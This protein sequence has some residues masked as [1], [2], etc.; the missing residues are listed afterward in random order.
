MSLKISFYDDKVQRINLSKEK[1]TC[2]TIKKAQKLQ[3]ALSSQNDEMGTRTKTSWIKIDKKAPTLLNSAVEWTAEL[4]FRAAVWREGS[5]EKFSRPLEG[6]N[7]IVPQI[8]QNHCG[9][10]VQKFERKLA[11]WKSK[12][13]SK[14]GRLTSVQSTLWS[15]PIY[16]M[17]YLLFLLTSLAN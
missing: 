6:S 11:G 9:P 7:R 15:I 13:L 12:L 5:F 3:G 4:G 17:C 2:R 10:L 8:M 1:K 16:F 14:G